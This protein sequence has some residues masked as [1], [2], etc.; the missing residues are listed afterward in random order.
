MKLLHNLD[1]ICAFKLEPDL[2]AVLQF[3]VQFQKS[4]PDLVA[5]AHLQV[6]IYNL[7]H[8]CLAALCFR[9][10]IPIHSHFIVLRKYCGCDCT[11]VVR[12]HPLGYV[13]VVQYIVSFFPL[14]CSQVFCFNI[15][16]S[17]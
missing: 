8:R 6:L 15:S 1:Q 17:E 2:D 9:L 4:R 12:M 3:V 5:R 16:F 14:P 11:E 13:C 10:P 7:I